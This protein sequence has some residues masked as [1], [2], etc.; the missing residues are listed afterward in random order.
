MDELIKIIS[1]KKLKKIGMYSLET[2]SGDLEVSDD[3][4]VKFRLEV[5]K[6]LS[7]EEFKNLKKE[8]DKRNIFFAVCN[9][10]SYGMRSEYEIYHYLEEHDV[11]HNDAKSI[12][13]ELKDCKMIDDEELAG[14]ILD[15]VIRNKKGPKVFQNKIFERH[16][17]VDLNNYPY[18]EEVE[19]EII[20]EV[21]KKLYDKKKN[22]PIKKQK[23]Q[24]Y[25][26]L[27][28]D[29]F[30]GSIVERMISKVSFIDESDKTLE[31]E[32]E[33]LNK[34]YEKLPSEEKKIK[35]I[36]SL[37]QKGYEYSKITKVVR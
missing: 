6:E 27:L 25:L 15:S 7:K 12:V 20:A 29:G 32:V 35:M 36:R 5:D 14:Y 33:K 19:E 22:L 2:S 23:E 26:K 8:N 10:I 30:T 16:V 11:K 9:Y 18:S 1:I 24:L 21:I 31:K 4:I 17:K 34:K 13:G 3:I 28:R 37:M